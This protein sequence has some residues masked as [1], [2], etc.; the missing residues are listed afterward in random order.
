[1]CYRGSKAQRAALSF[2]ADFILMGI[3]IFKRDYERV[4][5]ELSHKR[6]HVIL[7]EAQCIKDVGTDNY[8]KYRD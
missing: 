7:D 8:K 1:M 2:D 6:V 4:V 5:S 3:Q